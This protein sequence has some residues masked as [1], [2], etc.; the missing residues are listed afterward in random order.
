M[1]F[2]LPFPDVVT[3]SRPPV[4]ALGACPESDRRERRF[5]HCR[6]TSIHNSR[7][8]HTDSITAVSSEISIYDRREA[9]SGVTAAV[10]REKFSDEKAAE[11][12]H[13]WRRAG[14]GIG[15]LKNLEPAPRP[16][17]HVFGGV[18]QVVFVPPHSAAQN[19]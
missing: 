15:I 10:V 6:Y 5:V 19:M 16:P 12:G 4:A 14:M 18:V 3:A 17:S 1:F 2:A 8:D 13:C 11:L 9:P 7:A